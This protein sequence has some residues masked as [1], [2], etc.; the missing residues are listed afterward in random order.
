MA[1]MGG[2]HIRALMRLNRL[3]TPMV[4]GR[5]EVSVQCPVQL[6]DESEPEP[7]LALLVPLEDEFDERTLQADEVLL[8]IEVAHTS[9]EYDRRRKRPLYARSGIRELWIV[10]LDER[11]VEVCRRPGPDGYASVETAR[12]G[13]VLGVEALPGVE[14]PVLKAVGRRPA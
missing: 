13:Q 5:A 8:L 14:V 11:V 12:P 9:L 2:P 6:D 1:S 10:D 4:A 3:L 7:D